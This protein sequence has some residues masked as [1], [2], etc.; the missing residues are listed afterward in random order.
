MKTEHISHCV[1]HQYYQPVIRPKKRQ[2]CIKCVRFLY[3]WFPYN[4]LLVHWLQVFTSPERL[5]FSS[6]KFIHC[7]SEKKM[8]RS[9]IFFFIFSAWVHV[10]DTD[11][12]M[13]ISKVPPTS[14]SHTVYNYWPS[15]IHII[16]PL[17]VCSKCHENLHSFIHLGYPFSFFFLLSRMPFPDSVTMYHN[18]KV[19]GLYSLTSNLSPMSNPSS[20]RRYGLALALCAGCVAWQQPCWLLALHCMQDRWLSDRTEKWQTLEIQNFF[21]FLCGKHH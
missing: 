17:S 7:V 19:S 5:V 13:F 15:F 18:H 9:L 11:L 6:K 16:Q 8:C 12:S 14:C 10:L 2:I 4:V 3:R 20:M 21:F 1:H